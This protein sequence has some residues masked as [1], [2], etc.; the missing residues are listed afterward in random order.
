MGII[1]LNGNK[2]EGSFDKPSV[3]EIVAEIEEG[4]IEKE[5]IVVEVIMDGKSI[6]DFTMIDG[7]LI[8]FS[9]DSDLNI[10][11][12]PLKE[13]L[14]SSI[15]E[16]C[17]YLERLIPGLSEV[18]QLFRS[19]AQDEANRLYV[20][21]IDGIRV[22]IELIQGM[23]GN[24]SIDFNA[25][26]EDGRSLITMTEDLK[27]V[28]QKMVSAQTNSESDKVAHI[29]ETSLVQELESWYMVLPAIKK[30]LVLH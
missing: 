16:F 15:D 30:S 5:H 3:L 7:S 12:R 11:T 13:I 17:K 8:P 29:L 22:M 19:E 26:R 1:T 25:P 14:V 9:S 10:I 4:H 28:L 21:A 6:Q 2:L 23:S 24:E 20:E 18:A 27:T